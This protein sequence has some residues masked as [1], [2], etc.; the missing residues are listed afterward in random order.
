VRQRKPTA[1]RRQEIALA[2]LKVI[3]ERGLTSLTT[4]TLSQEVGVTTGALFRH[5][6]SFDEILRET[7][8]RAVDEVDATFPE[9]SLPPLERLMGLARDRIALLTSA[10]GLSWLLRSEQAYLTLPADAVASLQ[11]VV[12]RSRRYLLQA[13]RE[14]QAQGSIRD[15]IEPEDLLVPIMGTIHA[16]AGMPGVHRLSRKSNTKKRDAALSALERM[17]VPP[18]KEAS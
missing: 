2:V 8:R 16:L 4:A 17:I 11:S 13:I 6:A 10:P 14:G 18:N 1:E 7:V 9:E 15:D 5:F 3:G 12:K